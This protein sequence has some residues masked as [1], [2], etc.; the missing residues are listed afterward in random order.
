ME[1]FSSISTITIKCINYSVNVITV[2]T[3][4]GATDIVRMTKMMTYDEVFEIFH[5]SA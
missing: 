4:V 2:Q 5:N 3:T 1:V